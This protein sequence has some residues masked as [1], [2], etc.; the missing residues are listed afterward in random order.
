MEF[1]DFPTDGRW[2][3]KNGI[4]TTSLSCWADFQSTIDELQTFKD[5]KKVVWRG[6]GR[7]DRLLLS[8]FD[9]Y[10]RFR[11]IGENERHRLLNEHLDNLRNELCRVFGNSTYES[12]R[13]D[14][15]W[16]IGQHYG[17]LTPLLDW[18]VCP[19]IAAYFA[20]HKK[21]EQGQTKYRVV[22]GLHKGI[23]LLLRKMKKGKKVI[24]WERFVQVI[25][26]E[27]EDIK[28]N[29]R[30]KAQKGLFTRAFNGVDIKTNVKKA[31]R[32]KP[33]RIYLIEIKIPDTERKECLKTLE[34]ER[35]IYH[36]VLFPD[37]EGVASSCNLKLSDMCPSIDTP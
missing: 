2:K 32:K 16:A 24:N 7:D 29:D 31:E 18:T 33:G 23:R 20:F 13:K 12:E 4:L 10:E 9:R 26:V 8:T 6:E 5:Y 35:S 11:G 34:D 28:N 3:F 17:M 30:I 36:T 19:F 27:H 14:V 22:Y 21:G 1:K 37:K 25:R 15:L